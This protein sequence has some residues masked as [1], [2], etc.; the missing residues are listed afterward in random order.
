MIELNFLFENIKEDKYEKLI[1][2]VENIQHLN[3]FLTQIKKENITEKFIK[4]FSNLLIEINYKKY[5]STIITCYLKNINNGIEN[6]L[7]FIINKFDFDSNEFDQALEYLIFLS[8]NIENVFNQ[9]LGFLI[10]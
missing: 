8:N 2:Q 9:A 10:I 3:L 6:S 1:K 7:N 5:Y 4:I